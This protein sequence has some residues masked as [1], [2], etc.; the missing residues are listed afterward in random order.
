MI[1]LIALAILVLLVVRGWRRGLVRQALD[2]ATLLIGAALAFRLAPVIGRMMSDTFGWSPELARVVGG[3]MLFLALSI[4]AG[5]VASAIHGSIKR[6]PGT[7]LLNN[8]AG[9]SLG[10][11]YALVLAVAAVTLLSAIPLPPALAAEF[12]ES[13]V[14]AR[15]V[16]AD[17]PAQRAVEA[18]S[19]DRAVQS[20]IWLRRLADDWL[21]VAS[22][23]DEVVLPVSSSDDAKASSGAALAVVDAI[24][25]V[26]ADAGL[27]PVEWTDG[28][29]VVAVA[30]ATAIYRTGSFT[31][32]QPLEDRLS[33]A[34]IDTSLGTERLV[35][36]PTIEGAGR[37]IDATGR[38]ARGGV[39]VVDGPYGLMVVLVLVDT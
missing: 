10:G 1:D 37:A 28:L 25:R 32:R 23:D 9:A 20:I 15:V 3:G 27:K 38:F 2:V 24:D 14:A 16:A 7:S 29:A 34:G 22:D 33:G 11:V 4:G 13:E 8:V 36:A 26:R 35:L 39:G 19:G 6:L 21:L 12:E 31:S 30:R 18:V 17:G 5:F